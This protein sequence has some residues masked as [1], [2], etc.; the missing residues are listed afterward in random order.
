MK[1]RTSVGRSGLGIAMC[2]EDGEKLGSPHCHR[3]PF[4]GSEGSEP[5]WDPTRGKQM[6]CCMGDCK[7]QAGEKLQAA[8]K[9]R[10]SSEKVR[11]EAGME[12]RVESR[13]EAGAGSSLPFK[14]EPT[15][16]FF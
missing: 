16:I 1:V 12:I 6:E 3:S 13:R 4:L 5:R 8:F 10:C 14:A 15:T 2:C 9:S 11:E 7:V